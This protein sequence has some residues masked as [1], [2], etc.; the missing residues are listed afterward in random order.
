M[1]NAETVTRQFAGATLTVPTDALF[2]AWMARELGLES[3][4]SGIRAVDVP[5]IGQPWPGQGGINGGLAR[6]EAGKPHWLIVSPSDVGSF[7]LAW[8]GRNEEEPGACSDFDGMAN[9]I[10]LCESKHDHPAAQRCRELVFEGHRDYYLM[11]KRQG[12]AL[13]ANVPELFAGWHWTSTQYSATVAWFQ[14]FVGGGQLAYGKVSKG[15]V[16]AV[17]RLDF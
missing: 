14:I 16:R 2:R 9:T 13:Y 1:S 3:T 12:A 4:P 7:S 11:A 17:R 5:L 15:L 8:G 6:D 10:A